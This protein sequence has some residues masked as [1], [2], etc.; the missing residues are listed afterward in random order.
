M[1][2]FQYPAENVA[3]FYRIFCSI[4]LVLSVNLVFA[5]F[6]IQIVSQSN[7]LLSNN[8]KS[9]FKSSKDLTWIATDN[10]V[11]VYDGIQIKNYTVRHGLSNNNCWSI[12]EDK[13]KTIWIGTYGGGLSYFEE[14]KFHQFT[15]NHLLSNTYVRKLFVRDHYLYVGTESGLSIINLETKKIVPLQYKS[16]EIQIMDFFNYQDK[17]FVVSFAK[18]VFKLKNGSLKEVNKVNKLNLFSV[19]LD[20]ETLYFGLDGNIKPRKS[21]AKIAVNDFL[22]GK[23]NFQFFGGSVVW[24]LV[25]T[26]NDIF[27]AS[28]G[29]SLQSGGLFQF[30]KDI[31]VLENKF[32]EKVS[33]NIQ[34]LS[35]DQ[36]TN[37]LYAGSTDQGLFIIDLDKNVLRF[38]REYFLFF[39]T[40]KTGIHTTCTKSKFL[41]GE[42]EL[43]KTEFCDY[44]STYKNS[45]KGKKQIELTKKYRNYNLVDDNLN[46]LFEIKS[47]VL[48]N[49]TFY[50]NTTLGIF[51]IVFENERLKINDYFPF[52]A[53]TIFVDE[54]KLLF[55]TPYGSFKSHVLRN[56]KKCNVVGYDLSN[57]N[58]PRDVFKIFRLE[59][60]VYL[61]SRFN[62]VFKYE[63]DEFHHVFKNTNLDNK[64]FIVAKKVAEKEAILVNREGTIFSFSKLNN[65]VQLEEV[66]NLEHLHGDVVFDVYQ[67][68]SLLFIATNFG[69]NVFQLSNRRRYFLDEEHGL[70]AKEIKRIDA[71][72]DSILIF[73][74]KGLFTLKSSFVTKEHD[75]GDFNLEAVLLNEK[76]I[77]WKSGEIIEIGQSHT[78]LKLIL[79]TNGVKYPS[80]LHYMYS[81][82]G[83][84]KFTSEWKRLTGNNSVIIPFIPNGRSEIIF[85]TN[86]LFT[87][88]EHEYKFLT[89]NKA[90]PFYES[91]LFYIFL[92]LLFSAFGYILIKKRFKLLYRR[93]KEKSLLEKRLEEAKMEA[94]TSQMS[95]HFIFNSLNSIQNFVLKNDI[96]NSVQYINSFSQLIRQTLNYSSKK[97]I[98]LKQEIDYLDLYVKIQNLRFGNKIQFRKNIN[99]TID[100]DEAVIPPLLLQP[101]IEN[102]FEHAF[103]YHF[104]NPIIELGVSAS[105]SQIVIYIMDNGSGFNDLQNT[106]SKGLKLVEKRIKILGT[107]NISKIESSSLGTKYSIVLNHK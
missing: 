12:V 2:K 52:S 91:K 80:K 42:F 47:C 29:V 26:K 90:V 85:K 54:G 65:D 18:G 40:N 98:T 69:L 67:K 93:Q 95:P 58:N 4:S 20:G 89:L 62:G 15:D 77:E 59:G 22:S 70:H 57:K 107:D 73:T 68:D 34:C 36:R 74:H 30:T 17:L 32:S 63:H 86:N 19:L 41:H 97:H 13:N 27:V 1:K 23:N 60:E 43:T 72:G 8:I 76:A 103:D 16:G 7:G 48:E 24:D 33:K 61:F 11:S 37:V 55:Q 78:N 25:K 84:D 6:P 45:E 35:Y 82:N 5:K 53:S 106:D 38:G 39:N 94:L 56:N 31:P 44:L 83:A 9:V 3:K 96:Q 21:I 50:L 88:S 102:C 66:L 64:E 28:W 51:A 104:E 100:L 46:S 14:G 75:C 99:P 71:F 87:A 105:E 92:A 10:G 79:S 49:D 81:I 101:I